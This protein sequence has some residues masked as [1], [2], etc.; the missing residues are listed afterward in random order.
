R[1][2]R[3]RKGSTVNCG[4]PAVGENVL[5]QGIKP[6]IHGWA[7]RTV[8]RVRG[9]EALDEPSVHRLPA[10]QRRFRLG[11]LDLGGR[12]ARGASAFLQ[13]T[14][15]KG[16][17]RAVLPAHRLEATTAR[18]G[19]CEVLVDSWL[20]A[21]HTNCERVQTLARHGA[22]PERVENRSPPMRADHGSTRKLN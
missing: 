8:R 19:R 16:L 4:N 21:L 15:E 12:E 5:L 6:R 13:P 11:D 3:G 20:E 9:R 1:L 18:G 14:G 7:Q 17:P 22:A 10:M 2:R